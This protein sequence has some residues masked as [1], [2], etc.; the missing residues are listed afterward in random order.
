V[1]SK[2]EQFAA[3]RRDRRI[4]GLTI[5][6]LADTQHGHRRTVR[7]ALESVIPPARKTPQRGGASAGAV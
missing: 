4:E 5:R 7:Q 6:A 2:L 3:I 1:R